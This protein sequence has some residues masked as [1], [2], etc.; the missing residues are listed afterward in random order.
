[1][2]SVLLGEIWCFPMLFFQGYLVVISV[3]YLFLAWFSCLCLP[4]DYLMCHTCAYFIWCNKLN[5][6]SVVSCVW[7]LKPCYFSH[8]THGH[9]TLSE[10]AERIST[11]L[12]SAEWADTPRHTTDTAA[13]RTLKFRGKLQTLCNL[14][15]YI[16][17]I[18]IIYLTKAGICS[19]AFGAIWTRDAFRITKVWIN[20]STAQAA[21]QQWV[22]YACTYSDV[23]LN[24]W[25]R[26][27]VITQVWYTLETNV[28]QWSC[29]SLIKFLLNI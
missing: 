23:V 21:L 2:F 1:M 6:C 7:V 19:V 16:K 18:L 29:K 4:V 26:V 27:K 3:W 14:I 9:M 15:N 22:G 13:D 20:Y 25:N 5:R 12:K 28:L 17:I 24:G 11:R 10:W 8:G